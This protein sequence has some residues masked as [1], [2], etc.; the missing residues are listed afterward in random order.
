MNIL[1]T[2][3]DG[4]NASGLNFLK[5]YFNNK[6]HNVFVVAPDGEKS[7]YSHKIT[8]NDAVRLVK[9]ED[10]T[11]VLKGSPADCILFA[12]IGVVPEK[13]DV[14][15]SGI[16]HGPNIGQDIMYSG[17]VAAARQGCFHNVPSFAL[18]ANTFKDD[19]IFENVKIFLDKYFIDLYK[20]SDCSFFYNINFPNIKPSE[21]KGAMN[22]K[23]CH[24]HYY[25]DKLYFFDAPL[26][27]KYY[28]LGA[29]EPIY[30]REE[31]TDAKA[32]KE[33]F[34]SITA[35]KLLPESVTLDL[36]F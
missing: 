35:V 27:G 9:Q 8:F 34:I 30:N 14:I 17:T 24:N 10:K 18:S 29:G 2:N 21:V 31:G 36:K 28:W 12:L 11:W 3:D 1:L 32:L 23:I 13:I 20:L 4:F 25:Q 7:G 5:E 19:I 26:Q 22:T 33:G 6:G 15:I 16:N